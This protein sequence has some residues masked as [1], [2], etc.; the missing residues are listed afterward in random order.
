MTEFLGRPVPADDP[1]FA[2]GRSRAHPRADVRVVVVGDSFAFTDGDGPQLPDAPQLWPNVLACGLAAAGGWDVAVQVLARPAQT[3][4]SAWDLV[5]KDRHAQFEVL[6]HA[7]VVVAAFGSYDHAPLGV[8]SPVEELVPHL[9][10][11]GLRRGVRRGLHAAYPWLV[12]ATGARLARTPDAEFARLYAAT[13][14]QL[15]A[16]G[17]A[18]AGVALGP[19]SHRSGYYGGRHPRFAERSAAQ[20]R[21]A[22][23]DGWATLAPWPLVEPFAD[24]LNVDG[25]HWPAEAHSAV[26]AALAPLV[27][28]Q[29]RGAAARPPRPGMPDGHDRPTRP[30][31]G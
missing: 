24:R 18:A 15:R 14:A 7:D 10:P 25:I 8:P 31:T 1:R 16:L 21:L 30:G 6:A 11:T 20:L 22:A 23:H 29:L 12:H 27:A 9:R 4:R 5:H 13:L 19:S 3:A 2:P 26:G 28:D 17:F